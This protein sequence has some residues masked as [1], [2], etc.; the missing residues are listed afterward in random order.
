M[1]INFCKH[2]TGLLANYGSVIICG[3][4]GLALPV[5]VGIFYPPE[6]LGVF[7][8]TFSLYV[9]LSQVGAFGIH[10]SVLKSVAQYSD[11]PQVQ[12]STISSGVFSTAVIA[13]C[14]SVVVW[15]ADGVIGALLNSG[16]VAA[17]VKWVALGLFFFAMN[18][19]L[20]AA[21]NSLERLEEYAVYSALRYIF[22]IMALGSFI[23]LRVDAINLPAILPVAEAFLSCLLLRALANV[24]TARGCSIKHVKDHVSFGLRAVGGHVMLDL[25]S[26]IDILCLGLFLDD[27]SI[28]LYSMAAILAEGAC[29]LPLVLRTVYNPR[30]IRLLYSAD[31]T[32]L[33]MFINKVR[34]VAW[35]GMLAVSILAIYV[36]PLVIPYLTGNP[37]Y[38]QGQWIFALLMAGV[39]IA[40]G[41]L[42]FGLMLV[43]GG[44]PER[45]TV[46]VM[47]LLGINVVGNM[48]LIPQFGLYGAAFA[49]FASYAFSVVL[50]KMFTKKYLGIII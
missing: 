7:N 14:T 44:Y 39:C 50:L 9:V 19:T 38:A 18:K 45:Q 4:G 2:Y 31:H 6:A 10:L 33:R 30:V 48:L 5:C 8:Q 13:L 28:G 43:N 26:R 24:F 21:L 35:L 40:S 16:D 22:M 25:N 15:F 47:L 37:D 41:Y 29:Q 32:Q 23:A 12:G 3:L 36:Y 46:M 1:I 34:N 11:S 27:R 42:P 17:A 49:T 20:L